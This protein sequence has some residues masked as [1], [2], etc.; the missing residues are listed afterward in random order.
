M[1]TR[2]YRKRSEKTQFSR[3]K[4]TSTYVGGTG[5]QVGCKDPPMEHFPSKSWCTLTAESYTD[6]A[7]SNDKRYQNNLFVGLK[8]TE[9]CH[10]L[11]IDSK[12]SKTTFP[13]VSVFFTVV[14]ILHLVVNKVKLHQNGI[15]SENFSS[16]EM[17]L[18]QATT[19]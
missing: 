5:A 3:K 7:A 1:W 2:N 11:A 4:H 19:T 6:K 14:T 16:Y 10:Y 13:Y 12:P 18:Q 8:Y 15:V 17:G 9:G